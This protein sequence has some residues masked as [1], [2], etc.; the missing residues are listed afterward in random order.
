M[1]AER[2]EIDKSRKTGMVRLEELSAREAELAIRESRQTRGRFMTSSP[3]DES[4]AAIPGTHVEV[5][6]SEELALYE[7][8]DRAVAEAGR[9]V[10]YV[11]YRNQKRECLVV[12]RGDDLS[13]LAD[14]VLRMSTQCDADD[15]NDRTR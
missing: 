2:A 5:R 14:C 9:L 7:S 1:D 10:P 4:D 8:I 12:I 3:C 15:D 11:A 13:R 6:R